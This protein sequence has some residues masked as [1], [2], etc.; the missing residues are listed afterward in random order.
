GNFSMGSVAFV[1][2]ANADGFFTREWIKAFGNDII[3]FDDD[4][5]L[6]VNDINI[7]KGE[8]ENEV[9]ICGTLYPWAQGF[10]TYRAITQINGTP[11]TQPVYTAISDIVR[12]TYSNE[13]VFD[14]DIDLEYYNSYSYYVVAW[15]I[16]N[17]EKVLGEKSDIVTID[18]FSQD[19]FFLEKAI[20]ELV[21]VSDDDSKVEELENIYNSLDENLKQF[22]SSIDILRNARI[23]VEVYKLNTTLATV[24][25]VSIQ[26]EEKITA[27]RSAVNAVNENQKALLTNIDKLNI[28]EKDLQILKLISNIDKL[29]A[30]ITQLNIDIPSAKMQIENYKKEL[31]E[32]QQRAFIAEDKV[33]EIEKAIKETERLIEES[34]KELDEAK[35][36]AGT[37]ASTISTGNSGGLGG[38]MLLCL[39]TIAV[40][41][42]VKRKSHQI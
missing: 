15:R 33:D 29:T 30:D 13:V 6:D 8:K 9:L 19:V 17:G 21:I 32:L 11:V 26:D 39:M 31:Y 25:V 4:N 34:K 28:A 12:T 10:I 2:N 16:V 35:S 22:V 3:I 37:A 38:L 5:I 36:C 7:A 24:K 23:L 14:N 18:I 40:A 20:A 42:I 27:L 1:N 41:L